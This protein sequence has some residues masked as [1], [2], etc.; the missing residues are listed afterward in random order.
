VSRRLVGSAS[1]AAPFLIGAALGGRT[2]RRATEK[3]AERVL[4]DLD[5]NR[6]GGG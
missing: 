6:S 5:P 3:L 4:A 1:S 2:N